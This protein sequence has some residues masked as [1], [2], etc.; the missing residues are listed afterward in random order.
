M[1]HLSVGSIF[2]HFIDARRRREDCLDDFRA[3]LG[4][5]G[6]EYNA[7]GEL[8]GSVDTYFAPLVELRTRL[9]ELLDGQSEGE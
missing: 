6:E 8:L 7:L 2:Y 3:W 5:F 9:A 4:Q 1:E